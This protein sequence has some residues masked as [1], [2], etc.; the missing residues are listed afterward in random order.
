MPQH[1][2]LGFILFFLFQK[3]ITSI[4]SQSLRK[5]STCDQRKNAIKRKDAY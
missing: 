3:F 1:H 2:F 4:P 5:F